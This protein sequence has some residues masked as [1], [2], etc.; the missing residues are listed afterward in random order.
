MSGQDGDDYG[1]EDPHQILKQQKKEEESKAQP[2]AAK[3]TAPP[4][5]EDDEEDLGGGAEVMG[6]DEEAKKNLEHAK[7][8]AKAIDIHCM[9]NALDFF[10]YNF[11]TG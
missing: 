6:D 5:P 8:N 9:F 4:P 3:K 10:C 7:A 1:I 11:N 2:A